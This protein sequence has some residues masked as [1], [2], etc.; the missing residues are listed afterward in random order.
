MSFPNHLV[1]HQR[2]TGAKK[3]LAFD[4]NIRTSAVASWMNKSAEGPV[5]KQ[6]KKGNAVQSPATVVH[7]DYTMTS[8]PLRLQ[9]LS[10]PPKA[11]DTLAKVPLSW[12]WAV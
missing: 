5:P 11:N 4:H 10:Q 8:A 6:I 7:N 3:V 12:D 1:L 9:L 2:V